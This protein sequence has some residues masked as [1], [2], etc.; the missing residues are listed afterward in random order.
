VEREDVLRADRA[1]LGLQHDAI[2]GMAPIRVTLLSAS[3]CPK[4][5]ARRTRGQVARDYDRLW[6]R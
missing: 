6:C 5:E 4:R 1:F 3:L 2:E